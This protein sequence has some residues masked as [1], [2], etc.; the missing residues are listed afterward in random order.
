[1]SMPETALRRSILALRRQ[2]G[3][4]SKW[5]GV[6]RAS[7]GSPF[8]SKLRETGLAHTLPNKAEAAYRRGDALEKRRAMMEAWAQRCEPKGGNVLAFGKPGGAA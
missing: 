4:R 2:S 3:A 7:E 8:S 1:M 6:D 5:A